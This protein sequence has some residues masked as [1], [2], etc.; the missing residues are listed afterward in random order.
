M[1][2]EA[3]AEP[4]DPVRRVIV[5][6]HPAQR[7]L[8]EDLSAVGP[9]Y[10]AERLRSLALIGLAVLRGGVGTTHR[11]AGT[12]TAPPESPPASDPQLQRRLRLLNRVVADE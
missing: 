11:A 1:P 7:E 6:I 3:R 4:F 9:R 5:N 10:R 8:V 2:A 12:A